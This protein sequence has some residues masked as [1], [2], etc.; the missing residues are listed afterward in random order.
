MPLGLDRD[1][2]RKAI[3]DWFRENELLEEV[4]PYRHSVGHSYRSH[5]PIEPYLSDQWYV[6]VTKQIT[7]LNPT[8]ALG[9]ARSLPEKLPRRIGSPGHGRWPGSNEPRTVRRAVNRPSTV[10][11]PGS[12]PDQP[13][14][15][16]INPVPRLTYLITFTCYGTWLHGDERG[17]VDRDHNRTCRHAR[18]S[19]PMRNAK[20]RSMNT[21]SSNTNPVTLR[22]PATTGGAHHTIEEVCRHRGWGVHAACS[23][24]TEPCPR[25]GLRARGA[26]EKVLERPS[27]L[28]RPVDSSRPVCRRSPVRRYG[29]VTAAHATSTKPEVV[30]RGMSVCVGGARARIVSAVASSDRGV[31]RK[32]PVHPRAGTAPS[33]SRLVRGPTPSDWAGRLR[34]HPDRYAKTFRGWHENIRDWCI[35]RQL[36]WG[37]RIP[38]WSHS[39]KLP[40]SKCLDIRHSKANGC[41][42]C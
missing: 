22:R 1:Q 9:P 28:T 14:P 5:V 4:K 32:P 24:R 35:S 16:W 20:P 41:R 37:H 33:R 21:N 12:L 3:V 36:W 31:S 13:D 19:T 27:S 42:R 39:C 11:E 38:V 25:R 23:V 2:A 10:R 30:D 17:S 29:P 26:R 40:M 18:S 34:F 7:S 6:C 8:S 15:G